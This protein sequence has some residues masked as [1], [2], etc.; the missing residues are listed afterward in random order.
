ML[1]TVGHKHHTSVYIFIFLLSVSIIE[2]QAA[3]L[4]VRLA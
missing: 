1:L 4:S 3:S 2:T